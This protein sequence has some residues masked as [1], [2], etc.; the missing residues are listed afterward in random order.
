MAAGSVERRVGKEGTAWCRCRW[1][2]DRELG[3]D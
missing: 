1:F 3:R 2:A